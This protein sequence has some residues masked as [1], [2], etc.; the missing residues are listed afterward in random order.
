M[1]SWLSASPIKFMHFDLVKV[2]IYS[3]SHYFINELNGEL[4]LPL[5]DK[6]V[7]LKKTLKQLRLINLPFPNLLNALL[8]NLSNSLFHID[9]VINHVDMERLL[10]IVSNNQIVLLHH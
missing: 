10:L 7:I 2:F 6:R 8:F 9:K 5:L 3:L 4:L 1:V